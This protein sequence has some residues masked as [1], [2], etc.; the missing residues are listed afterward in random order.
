MRDGESGPDRAHMWLQIEMASS[1]SV[2]GTL[3]EWPELDYA[4][5]QHNIVLPKHTNAMTLQAICL[6]IVH[7]RLLKRFLAGEWRPRNE[8]SATRARAAIRDELARVSDVGGIA[9]ADSGGGVGSTG[10]SAAVS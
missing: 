8:R 3:E 2:S 9:Q 5:I 1:G 7:Q 4:L 6:A 10:E